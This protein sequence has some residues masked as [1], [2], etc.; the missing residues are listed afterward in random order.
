MRKTEYTHLAQLVNAYFHQDWMEEHETTDA[1]LEE[2]VQTNWDGDV[3]RLIAEIDDYL[4]HHPTNTLEAFE[5]DFNPMIIIGQN[6]T[7][8][9][10][11]LQSAREHIVACRSLAPRRPD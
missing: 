3:L 10:Q 2:F 8:A 1:V 4:D 5:A 9:R 11:W 6:D 7:D